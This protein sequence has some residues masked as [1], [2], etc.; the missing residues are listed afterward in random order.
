MLDYQSPPSNADAPHPRPQPTYAAPIQAEALQ[1]I[2]SD[3]DDF[4]LRPVRVGL[5]AG[6]AVSVCWLDGVVSS[7][8]V[9]EDVLRPL[10]D[11]DRLAAVRSSREAARLVE[12][13]AVY[14][15]STKT[16]TETDDLVADL[17]A[18]HAAVIFEAL[19][20]AVTFEVK[21]TDTRPVAEAK[22]EKSVKGARDAFVE[23][24]RTN[25]ALVRRRLRTPGLKIRQTPVGRQS[26]T[27][28][29]VLYLDGIA[30]PER[31]QAVLDKLDDMDIEA[32]VGVGDLEPYLIEHPHSP[33]PQLGHTERPDKFAA[34][35]LNGHIGLIADGL[36]VGLVLPGTLPLLMHAPEDH[37]DQYLL[38]SGLT[39]LRYLALLLSLTL[40]A[41]Y[42]AIAMYHQEMI[43]SKLL[44]SVIKSE[45]EVP[46]SAPV[47]ILCLL[48]AFELLQEAG[49]RLPSS[50]GQTVSIIGALLVGEAAVTAKVASPIAIIVVALAGIAGYNVPNQELSATL[51]FLRMALVLAAVL[52]GMFGLTAALAMLIWYLCTLENAG[53]AYLHPF[54]DSEKSPLFRTLLRRPQQDYKFRDDALVR[55]NRRRQK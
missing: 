22:I 28:V 7:G 27:Q 18:G 23:T 8:D 34:A 5:R 21:S 17:A 54:V 30:A 51:R 20:L 43:P 55:Q 26:H 37:A 16:R 50:V 41:L 53:V 9:S 49:L 32:L 29:A 47:I 52:A 39:L 3:C 33:F 42:V 38:A 24:L 25:T 12:Q 35:L 10:T 13:G 2:F 48:V 15:C 46:F 44:L 45:Q 4:E 6:I 31:V 1:E 19:R 14:R 36:A 11:S 40:P